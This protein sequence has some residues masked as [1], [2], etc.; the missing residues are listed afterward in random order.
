[1]V[2]E[3]IEFNFSWK[4]Y[5]QLTSFVLL[6]LNFILFLL[7]AG[8][9]NLIPLR[10]VVKTFLRTQDQDR[11][12]GAKISRPRTRPCHQGRE[13]KTKAFVGIGCQEQIL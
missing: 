1:M 6:Y 3:S 10:V 9:Y 8:R 11:D 4:I 13:I 12:L 5:Q 7:Y 2:I